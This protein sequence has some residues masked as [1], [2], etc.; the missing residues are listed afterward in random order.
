MKKKLFLG[1]LLLGAL[2]LNSCVDNVE[3]D[4]VKAVHQAKAEQLKAKADLDKATGE[5]A[6]ITA[7]AEKAVQETLAEYQKAQAEYLR[8]QAEYEKAQAAYWNAK[9]ES[10]QA[11]AAQAAEQAAIDLEKA[12]L[13]L[14]NYEKMIAS[15][16]A[17][18]EEQ[19][20]INQKE[21][22]KA[23]KELEDAIKEGDQ[24]KIKELETLLDNYTT[25]SSKLIQAQK[26]LAG[27]K[28][29]LA[30]YEAGLM[31]ATDIV[32]SALNILYE[33]KNGLV[34][35]LAA[36]EAAL[37]EYE[38]AKGYEAAKAALDVANKELG[39]LEMDA[40]Y[41]EIA[42]ADAAT[43]AENAKFKLEDSQ[44][45]VAA[46]NV[47]GTLNRTASVPTGTSSYSYRYRQIF[48]N[49]DVQ[50][51]DAT[52]TALGSANYGNIC[53]KITD[54][55]VETII[56]LFSNTCKPVSPQ[57]TVS[58]IGTEPDPVTGSY[59]FTESYDVY[60]EY[61]N[62]VP[63]GMDKFVTALKAYVKTHQE[64]AL[65]DA[66][67]EVTDQTAIVN[68]IKALCDKLEPLGKAYT[69]AVAARRADTTGDP[70]G[71][72]AQAETDT[73]NAFKAAVADQKLVA[74]NFLPT[75]SLTSPQK[76]DDFLA[77]N[78]VSQ[79]VDLCK[80][81][82][83]NEKNVL[84]GLVS[85][86]NTAE[87]TLKAA[88][89]TVAE[90]EA[91][92]KTLNAGN[93]GNLAAIKTVNETQLAKAQAKLAEL[94]ANT[95]KQSKEAEIKALNVVVEGQATVDDPNVGGRFEIKDIKDKIKT[96]T[97]QI[98][99]KQAE[100]D[101]KE[102]ELASGKLDDQQAIEEL[103]LDIADL[104]V[105]IPVLEQKVKL[106]KELLDAAMKSEDAETP[107]E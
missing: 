55:S 91:D 30:K 17:K 49:N 75:I 14:A 29:D 83:T 19:L 84:D 32:V 56:P 103:K 80:D 53:A 67:K 1:A 22:L 63:G 34:S 50:I 37:K 42:Y 36:Y 70:D 26:D 89:K 7:N 57:K 27:K 51:L 78:T 87:F 35:K 93:E 5:A 54:N 73:Y 28:M 96:T 81:A 48:G 74:P 58:G 72:L 61:Y 88:Q 90:I 105:Q 106:A 82:Y 18:W 47:I 64:Q 107:A 38:N 92:A 16:E 25:A 9:A 23:K 43:A 24:A 39:E 4:S 41:K 12:K 59:T 21:A 3:S 77:A 100:I 71:N 95:K 60:E 62:L 101:A 66:T 44:Y 68:P 86:Q 20:Y 46:K 104:E 79:T 99:M 76:L 2:T 11:A 102:K 97:D 94:E 98:A 31:S 65:S 45:A 33:D 69:D 8:A 15:L 85:D 52:A 6:L 40:R 10:E 13:Q